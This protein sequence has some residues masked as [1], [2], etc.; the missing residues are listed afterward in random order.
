V[1]ENL[2]AQ[3]GRTENMKQI[4]ASLEVTKNHLESAVARLD[5]KQ[6]QTTTFPIHAKPFRI[7]PRIR[8]FF[9][10]QTFPRFPTPV[11]P[12]LGSSHVHGLASG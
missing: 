5:M 4:S 11:D 12:A 7:I 8:K 9:L 6:Q 10:P 3:C 2:L 1:S